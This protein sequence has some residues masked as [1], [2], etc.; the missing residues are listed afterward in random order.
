MSTLLVSQIASLPTLH[1]KQVVPSLAIQA[2]WVGSRLAG[3]QAQPVDWK[4]VEWKCG[5]LCPVCPLGTPHSPAWVTTLLDVAFRLFLT[6]V[7]PPLQNFEPCKIATLQQEQ[8]ANWA[9]WRSGTRSTVLAF[10]LN[11]TTHPALK[12]AAKV[13]AKQL[14]FQVTIKD[15]TQRC[16]RSVQF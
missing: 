11:K 5:P 6:T 3:F 7:M 10:Y 12:R 2:E 14:Q 4:S 13:C 15:N 16:H 9:G 8:V 1:W